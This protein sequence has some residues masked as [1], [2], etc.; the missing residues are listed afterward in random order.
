[1]CIE[2]DCKRR[3][4][5]NFKNEKAIY[6]SKHKKG[7]MCIVHK[8]CQEDGCIMTASCNLPNETKHIY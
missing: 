1:M 3:A 8:V 5:Y 6:C 2:K 4:F 7:N